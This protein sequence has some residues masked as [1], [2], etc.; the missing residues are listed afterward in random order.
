MTRYALL[1]RIS[2]SL[3][4]I[5]ENPNLHRNVLRALDTF[6]NTAIRVWTVVFILSVTL[7][8]GPAI[9]SKYFGVYRDWSADKFVK[10]NNGWIFSVEARKPWY[11]SNCMYIQSQSIDARASTN[12]E[13]ASVVEGKVYLLYS[14]LIDSD[15][16]DT[17]A[18]LGRWFF[19]SETEVPSGSVISGTLKHQCH[20]LWV[21]T[22]VFGPF[23]IIVP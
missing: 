19:E 1:D 16:S 21:S 5:F 2:N 8:V 10:V 17:R 7:I 12:D 4:D 11:R 3:A 6:I 15:N 20:F 23:K 13:L 9:E 14:K 22:T 18:Y